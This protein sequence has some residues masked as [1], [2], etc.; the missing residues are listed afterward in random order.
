MA[1]WGFFWWLLFAF[2]PE[3][4]KHSNNSKLLRSIEEKE[5]TDMTGLN[6]I[7]KNH[8]AGMLYSCHVA[9]SYKALVS[10]PCKAELKCCSPP[11]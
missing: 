7:F 11:F 3:L 9:I 6:K 8:D 1:L 10:E 4:V 5:K 2:S